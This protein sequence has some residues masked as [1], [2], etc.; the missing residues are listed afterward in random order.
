MHFVGSVLTEF[1]RLG[2]WSYLV[3]DIL[4]LYGPTRDPVAGADPRTGGN[5][6]GCPRWT[7]DTI[8]GSSGHR[9]WPVRNH[10]IGPPHVE[11][12]VEVFL[13]PGLRISARSVWPLKY[14]QTVGRQGGSTIP[15]LIG[16][17]VTPPKLR[18]SRR[19]RAF[20][21]PSRPARYHS[22]TSRNDAKTSAGS[23]NRSS[24]AR[25]ERGAETIAVRPTSACVTYGKF[26]GLSGGRCL[27]DSPSINRAYPTDGSQQRK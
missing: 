12:S 20:R 10:R 7:T 27:K 13:L 18:S 8:Q 22:R 26:P 6:A 23:S 14:L 21:M 24:E 1:D 15:V 19:W 4:D 25:N 3:S 17:Q 16:Q 11:R 9:A 5:F 2:N